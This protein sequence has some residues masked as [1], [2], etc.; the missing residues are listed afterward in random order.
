VNQ[1]YD[2]SSLAQDTLAILDSGAPVIV[3]METLRRATL[4][5]R[6]DPRS[7]KELLTKL[8]QRATASESTGRPNA[9]A[10]FDV[11]YL[12][13]SYHQ[14]FY[15]D[16]DPAVGLDG[17]SMVVKAIALSGGKDP[18]MEF[19]AAMIALEGSHQSDRPAHAAK[20]IAG[21]KGNALLAR[22][23]SN[24]FRGDQKQTVVEALTR[25]LALEAQE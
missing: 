14:W 9:L 20:A 25:S 13:E 16:P 1:N 10:W 15:K 22:N 19:A 18:A 11:G 23:L 3:R 8:Y 5:S 12:A 4:Y 17:Y 24:Q 7:A 21:A 2:S 6:K